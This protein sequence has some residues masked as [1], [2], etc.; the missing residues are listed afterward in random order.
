MTDVLAI[1]ETMLVLRT[2]RP[3]RL[4]VRDRMEVGAAGAESNVAIGLARLGHD[5]EWFGQ[6][7]ADDAGAAVLSA[8]RAEGIRCSGRVDPDRPT[9]LLLRTDRAPWLAHVG[10]HRSGSAGSQLAPTDLDE[11]LGRGPR[12][13]HTSGITGALGIT[14]RATV[15]SALAQAR[16]ASYDVNFRSRLT[17]PADAAALLAE[18]LPTLHVLFCGADELPV[19][20]A[21]LGR[22]ELSVDDALTLDLV[23]ELVI[24]SGSRGA[25]CRV[26]GTRF[27]APSH[28][29]DVVD[30]IG[31]GDA[32][33]AGYL[34][35]LLDGR[36]PPE[37]LAR[38]CL[39]AAYC[40]AGVGD[41]DTLPT[42]ADLAHAPTRR[43]TVR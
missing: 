26:G 30:E 36:T 31:A 23:P 8:L 11:A 24:K 2:L 43:T 13:V 12:V 22:P 37:R 4:A 39:V 29:V 21:A 40:V 15:V 41:T 7:G 20:A 35:A 3:G 34:S 18:V 5:V 17:T 19:L 42:R 33:A 1:G 9:G 6:V 38:G 16:L 25:A 14:A 28:A 10:Y 27:D 32:F